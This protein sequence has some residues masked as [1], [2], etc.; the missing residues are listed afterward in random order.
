MNSKTKNS[1]DYSKAQLEQYSEDSFLEVMPER[2]DENNTSIFVLIKHDYFSSDSDHGRKL[3][4]VYLN[5]LCTSSF[6]S[7]TVYL[8][9]K[10]VLLLDK[11]N[12]TIGCLVFVLQT[13]S[14]IDIHQGVQIIYLLI[15]I[16]TRYRKSNQRGIFL[17]RSNRKFI[18]I[19][20]C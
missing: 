20:G 17:Y 12:R 1:L 10:G 3:L 16:R 4:A 5:R 13:I 2:T 15:V 7:I 11:D 9:D 18:F 19:D 14:D 6:N 8:T